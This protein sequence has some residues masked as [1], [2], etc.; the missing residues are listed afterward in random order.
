MALSSVSL[1]PVYRYGSRGRPS[2]KT[3]PTAIGWRVVGQ[4]V[5]DHEK[6]KRAKAKLGKFI[7]ATNEMDVQKLPSDTMLQAYKSHVGAKCE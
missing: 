3:P 2:P 5:E 7:L 1:E 6:I 4:V